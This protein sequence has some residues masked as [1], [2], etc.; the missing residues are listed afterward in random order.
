[1]NDSDYELDEEYDQ[2]NDN[3]NKPTDIRLFEVSNTSTNS[4]VNID[5]SQ[6][7]DILQQFKHLSPDKMQKIMG[8]MS[9]QFGIDP[10]TIANSLKI[11]MGSHQT[12][13]DRLR[14]KIELRRQQLIEQENKQNDQPS[15]SNKKKK[16]KK[17]KKNKKTSCD[18]SDL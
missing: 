18:S 3:L 10:S 17:K 15:I 13:A 1:M 9:Q 11:N 5:H 14:Q 16:K 8:Q 2:V 7:P 12:T 4:S 6:L